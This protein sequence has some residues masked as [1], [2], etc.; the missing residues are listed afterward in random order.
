MPSLY[1]V[2]YSSFSDTLSSLYLSS[3]FLFQSR[4]TAGD[5]KHVSSSCCPPSVPFLQ[6]CSPNL[7][8]LGTLLSTILAQLYVQRVIR[9]PMSPRHLSH[10]A[11]CTVII[12]SPCPWSFQLLG[13]RNFILSLQVTPCLVTHMVQNR[14]LTACML[15][16]RMN[17]QLTARPGVCLR[18]L[19]FLPERV[20]LCDATGK[21]LAKRH[22]R[23]SDLQTSAF[24]D[25]VVGR[26]V[27]ASSVHPVVK[28]QALPI[29]HLLI[30]KKFACK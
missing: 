20:S 9:I 26:W 24:Q 28:R 22:Q 1:N 12:S 19:F 8:R 16:E 6:D 17:K 21:R 30:T 2:T 29:T 10:P 27:P 23:S 18:P 15:D 7:P 5:S 4:S 25:H 3:C 13:K 11:C 14:L